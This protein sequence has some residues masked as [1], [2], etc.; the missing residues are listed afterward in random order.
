MTSVLNGTAGAERVLSLAQTQSFD[1]LVQILDAQRSR[2]GAAGVGLAPVGG[3][4]RGRSNIVINVT[5][6]EIDP[7]RHAMELGLELE[8]AIV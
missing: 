2:E 3:Y 5:P 7:C 6:N 4:G 1:R 8:K